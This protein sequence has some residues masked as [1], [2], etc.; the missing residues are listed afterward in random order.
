MKL[1]YT[2]VISKGKVVKS[3]TL[4]SLERLIQHY[5]DRGGQSVTLAEGGVGLGTVILFCDKLKTIVINEFFLNPWSSGHTIRMYN[6]IP[7]KYKEM[8]EK[9][10]CEEGE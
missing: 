8:L 7:K 9:Y 1:E 4:E 5:T 10:E 3:Y 2:N 6:K